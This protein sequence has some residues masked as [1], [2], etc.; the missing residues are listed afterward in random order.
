MVDVV[1]R[2]HLGITLD[3]HC[4]EAALFA[5]HDEG[6]FE[7]GE[8]LH[9]GVGAHVLVMIENGHAVDVAHGRD[10]LGETS[11][12]PGL[13]GALLGLDRI[14]VYIVARETIL[15]GDEIGRHA[16]RHEIGRNG[17]RGIDRPGA[18][19]RS[20]ADA[21]HALHAAADRHVVLA[22]HDLRGGEVH[23]VEA[24]GAEAV[25]LHA[26]HVIAVPGDQRGDARDVGAGFADR[27]DAAE[28]DVVDQFR[29]EFVAVL[30]RAQRARGEL[31]RRDFMQRAVRLAAT[32]RRA[33]GVVDEC[34][35]HLVLP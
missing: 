16:L 12:L 18:A 1:Y 31:Q 11:F 27:I 4:V 8:R 29:V 7:R 25:D 9:V 5:H 24:R 2:L 21:A 3:R 28:N 33:H 22:G 35:C 23:G 14:G 20:H 19:F 13:R 6:R 34:V 10:G 15:C 17:R 26:R 32:A 30:E